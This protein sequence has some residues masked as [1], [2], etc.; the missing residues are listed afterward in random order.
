MMYGDYSNHCYQGNAVNGEEFPMITGDLSMRFSGYCEQEL[1]GETCLQIMGSGEQCIN[2][3]FVG[4]GAEC[5]KR[6]LKLLFRIR[7]MNG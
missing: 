1:P 6:F 5:G 3:S 7:I 4:A 2:D